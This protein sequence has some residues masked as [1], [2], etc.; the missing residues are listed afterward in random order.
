MRIHTR[1]TRRHL[2]AMSGALVA[3]VAGGCSSLTDS[4][5]QAHDPDNI[6][7]AATQ[8]AAGAEGLRL[9]ALY[10]LV[11]TTAGAE[12]AWLYGGYLTDEWK[13]GDSFTERNSADR[14]AVPQKDVINDSTYREIHR[15]RLAAEQAIAALNT[16]KAA[17]KGERGEM[18]F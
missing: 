1:I 11:T 12:S 6:P 9:G 4:L 17:A 8:S 13:S 7:P 18:Y 2:A 3:L 14:R 15:A 16:Y 5:L 10:R